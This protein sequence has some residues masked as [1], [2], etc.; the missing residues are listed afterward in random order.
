VTLTTEQVIALA[1]DAA[2]A[3]AGRALAKPGGWS[4]LGRSDRAVWGHCQG[5]GSSPYQVRV[6]LDGPAFKCSCPSRKFP[7]KHGIAL[8]LL[9]ADGKVA[10]SAEPAWVSEWLA[11]RDERAAAKE[12]RAAKV[13]ATP[14]EAEA[15]AR[16]AAARAEQ[17]AG[18]RDDRVRDGIDMGWRWCDDLARG[19][20]AAARAQSGASRIAARLVDAQAPG[21]ARLVHRFDEALAHPDDWMRRASEALGRLHL[22]LAAGRRLDALPEDLAGDVRVAL[23]WTQS[24]ESAL[25]GESVSDRWCVVGRVA[26]EVDRGVS[27]RTWLVGQRTGRRALVLAFLPGGRRD[28]EPPLRTDCEFDASMRFYP[29]RLPLRAIVG[30]TESQATG[31]VAPTAVAA[32]SISAALDRAAEELA[33]QPLLETQLVLVA[34]TRVVRRAERTILIDAEG[35]GLLFRAHVPEAILVGL[36]A[37]SASGPITIAAELDGESLRPMLAWAEAGGASAE[38]FD[39]CQVHADLAERARGRTA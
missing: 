10:V 3:A 16:E 8:M 9:A 24:R 2:S 31:A 36:L 37:L 1:P 7:C 23:G 5:S 32:R 35:R 17:R 33:R 26:E 15:R 39:C 18:Q 14:E 19:G 6:S 28:G 13:A 34:G 12:E 11:S 38:H 4:E 30:E 25:A 29:S 22:L 20:L 27:E 21:L